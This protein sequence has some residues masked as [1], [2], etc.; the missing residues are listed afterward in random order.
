MTGQ[1]CA[2]RVALGLGFL[3]GGSLSLRA[4]LLRLAL[5]LPL[6]P[7]R[8]A[9]ALLGLPLQPLGFPGLQ[10]C[11]APAVSSCIPL[12]VPRLRLPLQPLG[13]PGLQHCIV[14]YLLSTF[15]LI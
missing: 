3:T 2:H 14:L 6:A 8:L 10:R 12:T 15:V 11:V 4:Q 1:A 13:F 7:L 5:L 9:L